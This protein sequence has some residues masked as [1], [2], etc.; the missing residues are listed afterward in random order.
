MLRRMFIA[1]T[2]ST[3]LAAPAFA[4]GHTKDIVDTAVGAGSFT[5]LV[6]AVEAAGLVETLKGPGPFTVFAPTDAAFAALPAGT[7]EDRHR[8]HRRLRHRRRHAGAVRLPPS[9]RGQ[10]LRHPRRLGPAAAPRP[11]GPG[12]PA[13]RNRT[14]LSRLKGGAGSSPIIVIAPSNPSARSFAAQAAPA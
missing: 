13:P 4:D 11:Q 9:G 12:A 3:L 1:L 8:R 10:P 5:T 14:G 6:A 2:A 7:V